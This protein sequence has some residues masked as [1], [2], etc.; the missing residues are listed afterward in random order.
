M[1]EMS[2]SLKKIGL[3][4]KDVLYLI[5][6]QIINNT[7]AHAAEI[8]RLVSEYSRKDKFGPTRSRTYIY[9]TIEELRETHLIQFQKDGRKKIFYLT[10]Q[11]A[12]NLKDYRK[13]I[14]PTLITLAKITEHMKTIISSQTLIPFGTEPSSQEKRYLSKLVNVKGL[15]RWYTLHRLIQEGP[16][17]GGPLYKEMNIWFGWMNNH[18]YFYQVLR[19]LDNDG[20]VSSTWLDDDTRVHRIYQ[21]SDCG[22]TKFNLISKQMESH[23]NDVHQALRF[24]IQQIDHT[25]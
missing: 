8:H 5:I 10:E 4:Q 22:K 9:K 11:G 6:L 21:I 23:I 24:M 18:G 25:S 20:L 14:Y 1:P 15:I 2:D 12:E 13:K 7:P 16:L 3:T 19:E 17:H